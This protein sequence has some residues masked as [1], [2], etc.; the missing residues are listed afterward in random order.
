MDSNCEQIEEYLIERAKQCLNDGDVFMAKS[1][2]LTASN[3]YPNSFKIQFERYLTAKDENNVSEASEYFVNLFAKYI[4]NETGNDLIE[5]EMKNIVDAVNSS[6]STVN[7]SFYRQLF[8]SLSS[9]LQH[10]LLVFVVNSCREISDICQL[11]LLM[12]KKFPE[13]INEHGLKLINILTSSESYDSQN[14][15]PKYYQQLLVFDVLPVI[16]SPKSN[17]EI[18]EQQLYKLLE[19]TISLYVDLN[20]NGHLPNCE[21]S[22]KTNNLDSRFI[23]IFYLIARK[24]EWE[25]IIFDAINHNSY[26]TESVEIQYQKILTFYQSISVLSIGD[27]ANAPIDLSASN[28]NLNSNYDEKSIKQVLYTVVILFVMCLSKYTRETAGKLV[29]VEKK[30]FT[31]SNDKPT[32]K[33]KLNYGLQI[34]EIHTNNEDLKEGLIGAVKCFELINNDYTLLQEFSK[35]IE[36]FGFHDCEAYN[37]FIFDSHIFRAT[38]QELIPLLANDTKYPIKAC[39]QRISAL[40]MMYDYHNSVENCIVCVSLIQKMTE[41]GEEEKIS[42]SASSSASSS[43]HNGSRNLVFISYTPEDILSYCV[44]ALITCIKDREMLSLKPSDEGIGHLIVLSQYKWPKEVELFENCI[45]L[46]KKSNPSA[47]NLKFTYPLFLDYIVNPDILEEFMALVNLD[48]YNLE[49]KGMFFNNSGV[50]SKAAAK[51]MTTRGVNKNV[52][53]EIRNALILQMRNS[54]VVVDKQLLIN[55][56]VNEVKRYNAR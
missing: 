14:H 17:L 26:I 54:K 50:I 19:K 47:T 43:L 28:A 13:R 9:D 37:T 20:I 42:S 56:I 49:L 21:A 40:L 10:K 39:L 53:E 15:P 51:S 48:N 4:S 23:N 34:P 33:R 25:L 5:K 18:S 46:I 27:G 8:E 41:K 45:S 35:R 12:L 38:Y 22:E 29:L 36:I 24:L 2:F 44:E 1:W 16:L 6:K 7:S 55:F 30:P 32:K 11:T 52:K 31:F 3:L